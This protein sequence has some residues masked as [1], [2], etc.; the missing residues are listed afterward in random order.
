MSAKHETSAPLQHHNNLQ[1]SPTTLQVSPLG[2]GL[3]RNPL[4]GFGEGGLLNSEHLQV[5][6]SLLEVMVTLN[7]DCD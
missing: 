5:D 4:E 7:I 6:V 2:E 3:Y 1:Q